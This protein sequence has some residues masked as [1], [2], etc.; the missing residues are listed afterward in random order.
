MWLRHER[1]LLDH[2]SKGRPTLPIPSV[3]HRLAFAEVSRGTRKGNARTRA[4]LVLFSS[5]RGRCCR[6]PES[7]EQAFLSFVTTLSLFDKALVTNLPAGKISLQ[8]KEREKKKKRA[9][10][11]KKG[12]NVH[13]ARLISANKD[14]GFVCP[15]I[16]FPASFLQC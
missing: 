1:E 12:N 5:V 4:H 8:T 10:W 14:N 7:R 2:A 9:L 15:R 13:N 16:F 3:T 11:S 6:S